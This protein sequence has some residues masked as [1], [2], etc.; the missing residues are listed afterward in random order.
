MGVGR[1]GNNNNNGGGVPTSSKKMIQ[2]LKEIVNCPEAEIYAML[3]ECN[4][5][6]NEAV[7]RLLSQ[8]PFHEVKSKREKKKETKDVGDSRVRGTSSTSTRGG[9]G[10][11]DR[12]SSRSSTAQYGTSD[13]GASRGKSA[14]KKENGPTPYISSTMGMAGHNVN[15]R[16]P[17]IFDTTTD[18]AFSY[19]AAETLVVAPSSGFQSAWSGMPG[20]VSMADIVKMG[21]PQGKVSSSVNPC[22]QHVNDQHRLESPA[23]CAPRDLHPSQNYAA[24][25][26]E[27]NLDSGAS[28]HVPPNDDWIL[29]EEPPAA[30]VSAIVEPSV[31][32]ERYGDPYDSTN[33]Q[34]RPQSDEVRFEEDDNADNAHASY[35]RSV[36]GSNQNMQE[37][38]SGSASG[39]ENELYQNNSAYQVHHQEVEDANASVS[40]VANN[41]QSLSLP[42]EEEDT[43]SEE[44]GPAVKIPDHLQVQSAECSH[45]SFGSFGTGINAPYSGSFG[46]RA[47]ANN[48]EDAS[49]SA[50]A[51]SAVHSQARNPE[52]YEDEHLRT[53]SDVSSSQ[54]M[55]GSSGNF[56]TPSAPQPDMLKHEAPELAQANQYSFPSST[57]NYGFDNSQQ[58]NSSFGNSQASSQ[59][60]GLPS[61]SGVM[62][63]SNT[64]PSTLLASNVQQ[65]LREADLSYSPF[66]I[67]QSMAS[68]YSNSVSSISGPTASMAEAMKAGNFSAAQPTQNLPGGSSISGGAALPQH[69]AVHPYSQPSVPMGHFAAAN[70]IG[71]PFLPQSYTYMPSAFQQ[72]FAAGNN[73]YP[74]SLAAAVLPQYKNS[75]SVSSLPQAAAVASGYGAFGNSNSIPNNFPL[76]PPSA[77]AGTS[78][79][80]EELL[81]SQYKDASHLLSLQQQGAGSRTM[82]GVPG[83]T[84]YNSFQ[85]QN[86]QPAGFRQSQ[87]PSQHYGPLSGY[88]NFYHS[89]SGLSLDHQ[90]QMSR[91]GS[92]SGSQGQPP[93]KQNQQI[94]QNGY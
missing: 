42:K 41:F 61:L 7:N 25:V 4:M 34:F 80:Y 46:S 51:P 13:S 55:G 68:K 47:V 18:N 11:S 16:Q 88:P 30:S 10:G 32:S 2:S 33:Q 54:R 86:Q 38:N 3:K 23:V 52:Y 44:E 76:N 19:N 87:Q 12:Y 36:P 8:D 15:R 85:G 27:G 22:Q 75:V 45:L 89:Q 77:P 67:S 63:Y 37:D 50:D 60:Q 21:R 9:R 58:L 73:A 53:A 93:N 82:S 5:D 71:Y 64:L 43:P 92:L 66:P 17:P 48:E 74:Q 28:G 35:A 29:E 56:D 81:S 90:Q 49:L 14:Y 40:D 83:S 39:F 59:M 62:P 78:M 20:Q 57:A 31:D 72:A 69:L 26:L 24:K 70:M 84:Y 79:N 91:D 1:G 6:P 94:W 65:P